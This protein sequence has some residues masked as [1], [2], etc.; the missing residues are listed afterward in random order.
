MI[1]FDFS[2]CVGHASRQ[3]D[4]RILKVATTL[5]TLWGSQATLAHSSLADLSRRSIA[6]QELRQEFL[7]NFEVEHGCADHFHST[8]SVYTFTIS[9]IGSTFQ[10][11]R[12]V[13]GKPLSIVKRT[14][15]FASNKAV[16]KTVH[17]F[18]QGEDRS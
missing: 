1:G 6:F 4:G 3:K 7:K 16:I 18:I 10:Y 2:G 9:T 11:L 15:S 14:G 13:A 12:T 17:P 5:P 8:K